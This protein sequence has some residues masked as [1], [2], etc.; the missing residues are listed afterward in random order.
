MRTGWGSVRLHIIKYRCIVVPVVSRKSGGISECVPKSVCLRSPVAREKN[1]RPL[2]VAGATGTIGTVCVGSS[3]F[4]KLPESV[5]GEVDSA[6]RRADSYLTG[7]GDIEQRREFWILDLGFHATRFIQDRKSSIE[8]SSVSREVRFE[9]FFH[10]STIESPRAGTRANEES[11]RC[12]YYHAIGTKVS[13]S[14]TTL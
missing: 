5:R 1:S 4:A 7:R 2:R 12:S 8:N 14:A 11:G 6:C 13:L 10:C 9:S 3:L